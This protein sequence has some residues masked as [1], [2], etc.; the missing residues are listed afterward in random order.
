MA[1]SATFWNSRDSARPGGTRSSSVPPIEPTANLEAASDMKNLADLTRT[2]PAAAAAVRALIKA[3]H[4]I[5]A[6]LAMMQTAM[7][8]AA[9]PKAQDRPS[10]PKRDHARR[11]GCSN[12][13]PLSPSPLPNRKRVAPHENDAPRK[14]PTKGAR[15]TT[16]I[17][18]GSEEED[19]GL[20]IDYGARNHNSFEEH[21][22]SNKICRLVKSLDFV[23]MWFFTPA[24]CRAA[25]KD[26]RDGTEQAML[27]QADGTLKPAGPP[28]TLVKDWDLDAHDFRSA[29]DKWLKVAMKMGVSTRMQNSIA[30][31]NNEI[32]GHESWS[33]EPTPLILWHHHQRETWA[34]DR[35]TPGCYALHALDPA[36]YAN[37][38]LRGAVA[39]SDAANTRS[40]IAEAAVATMR[41]QQQGSTSSRQANHQPQGDNFPALPACVA[42]QAAPTTFRAATAPPARTDRPF[43]WITTSTKEASNSSP[44]GNQHASSST[45]GAASTGRGTAGGSTAAHG[46]RAGTTAT[47]SVDRPLTAA[48]GALGPTQLRAS[49]WSAALHK[50]GLAQRY[51]TIVAGIQ[52][53]FHVGLPCITSTFVPPNHKSATKDPATVRAKIDK[54]LAAGRYIGPLSRPACEAAVGGPF[55]CSPISLAPKPPDGWRFIQDA[56]FPRS[57]PSHQSINSQIR[58]DDWP[59]TYAGIATV[60][61]QILHLPP[62]AQAAARDVRSAYRAI[63]LHPSQW[64]AAVVHWE[65]EFFIDTCLAFGM[66]SSAG[67]W[68]IVGDALADVLRHAGIGPILKWVDDYLFFRVPRREL[69]SI[70]T[71]RVLLAARVQREHRGGV[72][73]WRDGDRELTEDFSTALL[74]LSPEPDEWAYDFSSVDTVCAPL[75]VPWSAEKEQ[76]FGPRITYYGVEFDIP[77]RI[78]SLPE[79][80]R[81]GLLLLLREW[82]TRATFR[83]DETESILGKLQF[84]T[85]VVPNGRQYLTGLVTFLGLY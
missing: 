6:A 4:T 51:P 44:R 2:N 84:A 65:G 72:I 56:S 18:V 45:L 55:Q 32:C 53:G 9:P 85:H 23:D 11:P 63:V 42:G 69:H 54:E 31:L 66:A 81:A 24:G 62:S 74:A 3:D 27:L 52:Q 78:V 19:D 40:A 33:T 83:R 15:A 36:T 48:R 46:A 10:T 30:L 14:K 67:A 41:Q 7:A 16:P 57:D 49:G 13:A 39:A 59:C 8:T 82:L 1:T 20:D 64:P 71:E 80:K 26:R 29:A 73:L 77:G 76:A 43:G 17:I 5:G 61:W 47:S 22:P 12:S 75:G 21:W 35:F 50:A 25:A 68:G 28:Q 79:R 60:I 37:I 38:R 58:S 70:N 34:R